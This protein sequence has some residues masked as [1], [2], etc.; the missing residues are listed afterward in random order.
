MLQI[1]LLFVTHL[2]LPAFLLYD[3]WKR[4]GASRF[5]LLVKVIHHSAYVFY[6]F[7]AGRWDVPGYYFRYMWMVCPTSLCLLPTWNTVPEIMS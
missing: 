4:P 1:L 6:I 5:K 3:L 7:L 2:F